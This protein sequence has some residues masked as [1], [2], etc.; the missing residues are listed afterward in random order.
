MQSTRSL[1]RNDLSRN[2][3]DPFSPELFDI[4]SYPGF[5]VEEY[6]DRIK[7]IQSLGVKSIISRGRLKIGKFEIAGKG[8]VSLVMRS[9]SYDNSICAL[10]IR[11][12]DANRSDM[13]QE[14]RLHSIA[15]SVG[16]G[17]KILAHS[18][19]IIL[20]EFVE[21]LSIADW[22]ERDDNIADSE[23][24]HKIVS[25]ILEQCYTLDKVNLDHGQLSYLNHHV[26]ISKSAKVT[27]IDFESASDRRRPSNVTCASHSLLLSG[28]ISKKIIDILCLQNK[29]ERLFNTLKLY[30][31]SQS[32]DN[33]D[34]ILYLLQK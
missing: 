16:I 20:M 17:P 31:L 29:K 30:K 6:L 10:K 25:D 8:C 9:E 1:Q 3:F 5:D 7:E 33:F 23:I 32:K 19:N 28:F 26:I 14:V 34:K 18:K 12:I 11:R 4:I 24:V 15:N 13:H 27:I 2:T 22:I 21:G